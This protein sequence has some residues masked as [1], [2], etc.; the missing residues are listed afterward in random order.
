MQ[1]SP[2]RKS[3]LPGLGRSEE[4][5]AR[6]QTGTRRKALVDSLPPP[7]AKVPAFTKPRVTA[8]KDDIASAPIDHRAAFLLSHIDGRTSVRDL[9]DV[10]GMERDEVDAL[11]ER[12]ELLGIVAVR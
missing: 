6:Q 12:L 5:P 8:S 1:K 10:S 2:K 4:V 11:L 3:T 7:S 9:V